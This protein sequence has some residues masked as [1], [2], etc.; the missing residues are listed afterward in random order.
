MTTTPD[1]PVVIAHFGNQP[2]Y[3][4][5]ALALAAQW[6]QTVVLL[7]DE[8]N[9]NFWPH[10]ASIT[11]LELAKWQEFQK[12]Y[13][14]L[15]NY[16]EFYEK[17]FWQRMFFLEFWMQDQGYQEVFLLDSD[18]A[19][20][21]NFTQELQLFLLN[22]YTAGLMVLQNPGN[23]LWMASP[24]F[25]YWTQAGISD[26]TSFCIHA[27][28][29]PEYLDKFQAVYNEMK[30]LGL[31]GGIC[32]MTLL[33]EWSQKDTK[34]FNFAQVFQGMTFDHG[35]S[36]AS[37]YLPAEY[38]MQFGLKKFIFRDG[39]PY[40]YNQMLKQYIRF[41]GI[42]CLGGNKWLIK[43]FLSPQW[44]HFYLWETGLRKARYR[45]KNWIKGT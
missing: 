1:I 23:L 19:T 24:H 7:G 22:K 42:H 43:R 32:E 38:Q 37:N 12:V 4:Q 2:E 10:H 5:S 18:V 35:I 9:K 40:G 15:S 14:K 13:V 29:N 17:A 21:A 16:D 3:L 33:Y 45:V 41:W 39:K 30:D 28:S 20:F 25:S 31:G 6:N 27:Y 26:F 36:S 8:H 34:V 11:G 44:R